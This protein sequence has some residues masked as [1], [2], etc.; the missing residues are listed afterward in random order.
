[1]QPKNSF[2][3]SALKALATAILTLLATSSFQAQDITGQWNGV[4]E[5][6]GIQLR[7]VFHVSEADNGYE[8]TMD[9]PDQGANGIP[10]TQ[11]T[12]EDETITFRVADLDMQYQGT[13]AGEGIE[14]TFRQRGIE[15]P[16]NL[17][18]EEAEIVAPKRPQE[19]AEPFP[20]LSEEVTFPNPVAKITLAGTLTLPEKEGKFPAVVLISGSGPQ[21]RNEELLG[22]KPFLVLADYLT[23]QGI[24]VLRFDDRGVGQSEGDFASATSADFAT[25]V[26]SAVAFLQTRNDIDQ[27]H[28]GLVGHSE[29]GLIAPMVAAGSPDI[30]FIVLLA[31]PGISGGDILMRQ[32]ELISRANGMDEDQ[33]KTELELLQ[34]FLDIASRDN[35]MEEIRAE[36]KE[37]LLRV[38]TE[39]PELV[40]EGMDQDAYIDSNLKQV[41]PWMTYFL[42]YDPVP[43]LTRVKCPVLALNGEK[44]LQVPAKVNLDAIGE[45]LAKGGNKKATLMELPNLNHLFQECETGSPS[46][47]A[48]LEETFSP[49]A[50]EA[51]GSW[52]KDQTR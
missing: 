8:A 33:I 14:G 40:P 10:V 1:M 52:I 9:S 28:L 2:T 38:V 32:T 26:A 5:V 24:A 4:L 20:Y 39:N 3:P 27:K 12:L 51:V 49:R 6:Q 43:A 25:D 47:Y 19:P 37:Y 11:T 30:A 21:N 45:A 16:M 41:T 18:R 31:G 44:D 15:I 46:E 13:L 23:R 42:K 7:L 36:L 35:S 22:H 48:K 34:A 29:G 17:S 50:L